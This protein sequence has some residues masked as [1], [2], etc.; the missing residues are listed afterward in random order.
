MLFGFG[1]KVSKKLCY[2]SV[3]KNQLQVVLYLKRRVM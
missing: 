3:L 2:L 1:L